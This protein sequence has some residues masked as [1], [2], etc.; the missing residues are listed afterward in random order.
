MAT[1]RY[2]GKCGRSTDVALDSCAGCGRSLADAKTMWAPDEVVGDRPRA[3]NKRSWF[4]IE[5]RYLGTAAVLLIFSQV[6]APKI[7]RTIW[8]YSALVVTLALVGLLRALLT[9][10]PENLPLAARELFDA[11]GESRPIRTA[12]TDL[13]FGT[14]WAVVSAMSFFRGYIGFGLVWLLMAAVFFF[15]SA[16]RLHAVFHSPTDAREIDS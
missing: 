14:F 12:M 16:I 13:V 10:A 7:G 9:A 6:I 11:K 1:I 15:N 8:F 5:P 2:C 4:S 3:R